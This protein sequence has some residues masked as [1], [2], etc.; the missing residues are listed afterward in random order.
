MAFDTIN[1]IY[2]TPFLLITASI[3]FYKINPIGF[4]WTLLIKSIS[5]IGV[6]LVTYYK[7][8]S[9]FGFPYGVLALIFGIIFVAGAIGTYIFLCR[10]HYKKTGHY[11][12]TPKNN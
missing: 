11:F 3:L 5:L 10:E 4:M 8:A 2:V 7:V 6:S 12:P 9:I 1:L